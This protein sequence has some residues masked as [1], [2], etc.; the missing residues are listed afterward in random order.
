MPGVNCWVAEG[1]RVKDVG[2]IVK[3]KT[4]TAALAVREESA[5]LVTVTV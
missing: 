1:A 4:L 2:E 5:V 3:T